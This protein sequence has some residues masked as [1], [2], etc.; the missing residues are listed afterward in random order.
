M[1]RAL[2]TLASGL[3]LA[4]SGPCLPSGYFSDL[5]ASAGSA[6]TGTLLSEILNAILPAA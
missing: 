6:L 1:R 3:L 5:L 4:F 2:P